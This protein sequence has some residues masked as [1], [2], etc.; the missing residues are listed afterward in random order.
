MRGGEASDLDLHHEVESPHHVPLRSGA[1]VVWFEEAEGI[2]DALECAQAV[3]TGF[4]SEA[5]RVEG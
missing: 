2:A 5:C 4:P 1:S 3:I